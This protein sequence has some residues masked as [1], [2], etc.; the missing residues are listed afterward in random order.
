MINGLLYE[1]TKCI[2]ISNWSD[3]SINF[4]GGLNLYALF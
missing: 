1:C 4:V 2:A 3:Q